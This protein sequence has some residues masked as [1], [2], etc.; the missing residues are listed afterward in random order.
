MGRIFPHERVSGFNGLFVL[1]ALE[2]G[3][4]QFQLNLARNFAERIAGLNGLKNLDALAKI[5]A[6]YRLLRKLVRLGDILHLGTNFVFSS[7]GGE[8]AADQNDC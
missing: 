3:M 4:Q 1:S 5:I 2:I 8:R 7:T 6:F